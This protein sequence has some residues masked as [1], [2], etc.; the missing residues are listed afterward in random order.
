MEAEVIDREVVTVEG[1]DNEA[2]EIPPEQ[3]IVT[4]EQTVEATE[5]SLELD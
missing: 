2:E 3:T 5:Q 1:T 4:G